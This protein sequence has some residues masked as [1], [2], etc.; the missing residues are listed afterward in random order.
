MH[1]AWAQK[2]VFAIRSYIP[3]FQKATV[4]D[5][6]DDINHSGKVVIEYASNNLDT[7]KVISLTGFP[8]TLG[9]V[10]QQVLKDQNVSIL[11]KNNKIILI[12]SPVPLPADFFITHY[13]IYGL[14]KEAISGEPLADATIWHPSL[15]KGSLSNTFGHYTLVLPE[16]KQVLFISYA[17]YNTRKLEVDLSENTRIDLTLEP[18]SNIQAVTISAE[19]KPGQSAENISHGAEAVQDMFL[20]EPDAIRSLYM[21]P[22]IKNIPEITNGLLVRGGSPD[23][24]VFLLDG[25]KVFNPTHLL[26]TL[27]IINKSA[28]KTL[29]LYKSNFPARYGGGLSSVIDVVTKDGNMQQWKGEANAGVLAGSFTLEGPI[30]K[31]RAA[32]MLSF[33]HSW[34]NPLLHVM[35]SGIGVNF[36]DLN[37]KYTQ[38]LGKKDKLMLHVYAGQDDLTLHRDY[39]NNVQRWGNRT[40]SLGWNRLL[41]PKAF[42]NTSV[43]YSEY[44]NIAGFRYNLYD[45]T[46]ASMQNRVYNTYSSIEQINAQT[47]LEFTASNT[48]R[49]I[50]GAKANFT[51][52]R[53]FDSNISTEFFDKPE[54]F[55]DFPPISFRELVFFLENEIR[56]DKE[57]F[58]RPGIHVSHFTN[59]GFDYTSWQPRLYAT[60]RLDKQHQLNFSYNHMTQYLHLVTNPYLGINGDAWVPSTSSLGPEESDMVNL[61]Y[62]FR[63]KKKLI[64]SAEVY[65]KELRNVTNYVEGKNL[66]LNTADWE[67]NVQTG[68]GW[69]YG[70]EAKL[71][72]TADDWYF[73]MGYTL[74]WN[75]RK[76]KG[77]NN[78]EKFPFKYDRRHSLNAAAT[79]HLNKHWNFSTLW[80]F[81]TGDVFTLPDRGY[82]DFD[83][84]QQIF[85]PL[86]PKEYRLIYHSSAINQ[87]R[88]LPYHRLDFAATYEQQHTARLISRITMGIYNIYG[89]PNQYVYD[90]EGTMGKRSLVVTTQYQFF[91]ITP[92][93]SY[94]FA[95]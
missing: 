32:I 62:T 75:W 22:G 5:F 80:T 41:G 6:L 67:Q 71:E 84:A 33:R 78:D 38:W 25:N 23:Q 24:N 45:S 21:Q 83:D 40:A 37:V 35:N 48:L 49:F 61:G 42:I 58:V 26:G 94:T 89:S 59:N 93:I 46:G 85:N 3:S 12:P 63:N 44:K 17:G 72:K 57:F 95:F 47:R 90:L 9:A 14:I 2:S 76:F 60:Y 52:V 13:S 82:P 66:F 73:Q 1:M 68:K 81:S 74:S 31:D 8:N 20:G 29:N 36:Y 19:S 65:Y 69:C 15:Q 56:P 64:L 11:E 10:L 79:Y 77:I 43:N 18:K 87:Y 27:F 92:Y 54:D 55:T 91:K 51:K 34:I 86:S 16:G 28:V 53:P 50:T 88:T 4:K 39:T 70:L 7:A 30:K